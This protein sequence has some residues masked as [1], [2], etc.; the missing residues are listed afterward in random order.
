MPR[1]KFCPAPLLLAQ[2]REHPASTCRFNAKLW[3]V[4]LYWL[5][6]AHRLYYDM[7]LSCRDTLINSSRKRQAMKLLAIHVGGRTSSCSET[8]GSSR[9]IRMKDDSLLTRLGV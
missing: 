8:L 5:S 2:V 7:Q 6:E 4:G 1:F 9:K 3:C